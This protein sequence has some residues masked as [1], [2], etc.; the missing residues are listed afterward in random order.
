MTIVRRLI[1]TIHWPLRSFQSALLL[2]TLGITISLTACTTA[3]PT[4][5]TTPAA[6]TSSTTETAEA[7]PAVHAKVYAKEGV[8]IGGADPVAYFEASTFVPGSNEHAYDWQGVTW[9]FSSA[10]NRDLF[11]S[12]PQSYAPQYGGHCAWAVGAKNAL[13]P[14]DPEAW[15]IVEGKLYLN[16]NKRVQSNWEKDIP[17]FIAKA[18]V[19]WPSL[20]VQ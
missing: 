12:T 15:S 9:Q 10:E 16:A 13:V 4:A 5:D 14:I 8:A 6:A 17:G 20:S 1:V 7:T 11:A 3:T 19:N 2:T 18:D